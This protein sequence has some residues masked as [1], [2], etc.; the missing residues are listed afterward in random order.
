MLLFSLAAGLLWHFLAGHGGFWAAAGGVGAW[1]FQPRLFG[2]AHYATYDAVLS[3]LW[4]IALLAFARAA[5]VPARSER[6]A[7]EWPATIG[8]GLAV[9]AA[10]ATK[11]T[12]WFLPL[13]FLLW[14]AWTRDRLA[15]RVLAI[16]LGLAFLILF[17][18]D[19]PWW[20]E[21]VTGLFR[22]FRSN[23]TAE[24]RLPS[25]SSSSGTIYQ[26]P[27]ESLPWYNTL[28]LTGMATPLGFL[29]LAMAG[30]VGAIRVRDQQPLGL[31]ILGNW[32][33]LLTLR[34][35]PHTPGHDGIRLFL[36]AFGTLAI[37]AG[38]GAGY[39]TGW[40]G[41]WA[42]GLVAISVAEGIASIVLF[43]PVPLSYFSPVVGGLPGQCGWAWNR[44][45]TGT[46]SAA[47]PEAGSGLTRPLTG[48]S[49]SPR[50][51][52]PGYTFARLANFPGF[53][54][55]LIRAA[56]SGT[57]YKAAQGHGLP[58]TGS[59]F[60]TRPRSSRSRNLECL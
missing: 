22:F 46:P 3:S 55:N 39:L 59:S 9:G 4:V 52:P 14:T 38:L 29:V 50:I 56:R 45:I 2:H 7:P 27:N 12:G 57:S 35:L 53:T 16:G 51:R 26:T 15:V 10:L 48:Q 34:A 25:P 32:L 40:L 6:A 19:P 13:P 20:T 17:L 54:R 42:K 43:L 58:M 33:L 5:I 28:A 11:F 24:R 1:L 8:F 41:R 47:R 36:P 31:L 23:L 30:A 44:P 21:P 37:L 60:N 18:L 49:C